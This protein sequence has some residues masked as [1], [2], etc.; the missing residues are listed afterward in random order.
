MSGRFAFAKR[1]DILILMLRELYQ[2]RPDKIWKLRFAGDGVKL[3]QAI[4]IS[5]SIGVAAA[6]EYCGVLG[7]QALVEWYRSLD[8]YVHASESEALS[9][10]LLEAMAS[11]LPIIASDVPGVRELIGGADSSGILVANIPE[12]FARAVIAVVDDV[13]QAAELGKNARELC[14]RE[15]SVQTMFK[16]YNQIARNDV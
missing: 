2:R 8:V 13:A 14:L 16:K 3:K 12:A 6:V 4:E 1:Q 15:Y 7:P 10:S 9:I 5:N 11:G